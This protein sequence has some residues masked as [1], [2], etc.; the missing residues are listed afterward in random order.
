MIIEVLYVLGLVSVATLVGSMVFFS[1]VMAPLIFIKLE[2]V[3]AGQF[4]RSVFPWYYLV[5][6]GLSAIGALSLGIVHPFSSALLA[7]IGIAA[8]VARQVLMPS[9]NVH[10]DKLMG[11]DP[12]A[13][14]VFQR[15]HSLSVW[16]NGGQ[17]IGAISVLIMLGLTKF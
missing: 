4:V 16:I 7:V 8:L 14:E 10:R 3:T 6:A 15:L 2:Q 12:G 5:I 1:G 13:G 11:G 9:I 17:V